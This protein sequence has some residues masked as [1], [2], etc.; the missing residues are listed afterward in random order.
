MSL[1]LLNHPDYALY[2][3]S[4]LQSLGG[5]G[6]APPKRLSAQTAKRGKS[7]GQG[8]G[9][10]ESNALTVG[11]F[12]SQE[13]LRN[14]SS[15]G[16]AYPLIDVKIVDADTRTIELPPETAGEILIRGVPMMKEYWNKATKTAESVSLDGWFRTGDIGRLD[17][18]GGLYI[19][20][21]AKDL[22]IRGGENISCSEVESALY[23]H[24]SVSECAVFA[25][26][27]ERLG[28]VV[29]AAIVRKLDMPPFDAEEMVAFARERLA[30]FKVPSVLFL[31][32]D[33]VQL[34]RGATGKIPKRKVRDEIQ[35]GTA[36][37]VQILP[38]KKA[39]S[40]VGQPR[41]KM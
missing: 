34:P 13:Y 33:G 10:T 14:P 1:E 23:E 40:K 17:H 3:T 28:E 7:A 41:A 26:P 36:R 9:L 4:S 24:P 21:R 30:K 5:G 39:G 32:E 16:R 18:T 6:A 27:D 38:Q 11:T 12:S 20:D 37:C 8:W 2:D 22:I 35:A 19:M 15:C 29:A 25:M 31:W